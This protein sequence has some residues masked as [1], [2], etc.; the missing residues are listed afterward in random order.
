MLTNSSEALKLGTARFAIYDWKT[1]YI[2]PKL[3]LVYANDCKV[4]ITVPKLNNRGKI[5]I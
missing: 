1:G 2:L 3:P 5:L 4:Q